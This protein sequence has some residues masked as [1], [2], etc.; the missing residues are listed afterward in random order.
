MKIVLTKADTALKDC[1]LFLAKFSKQNNI[2]ISVAGD[3]DLAIGELL[4]NILNYG[5]DSKKDIFISL[6]LKLKEQ[7]SLKEQVA[8]KETKNPPLTKSIEG[9]LVDSGG[10]FDPSSY[11]SKNQNAKSIEEQSIGGLGLVI[12]K[13]ILASMSYQRKEDKNHLSFSLQF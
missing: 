7:V 12:A 10:D 3:L 13:K 6:E 5:Y 8:L 11:E 9:L 4:S 1:R 2:P